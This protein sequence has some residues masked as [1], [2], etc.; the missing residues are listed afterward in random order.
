MFREFL[1]LDADTDSSNDCVRIDRLPLGETAGRDEAWLRDLLLAHTDLLPIREIDASYAPLLP[2]CKELRTEAGPIDAVFINPH[3]RL[4]LVECKLWRNPEA[5]RKVVAQI[6]DYARAISQWSYSDLQRNVSAATRRRGNVPFEVVREVF[7]DLQEHH[8]VDQVAA[9][10]RGG[11]FL[12]LIVGD[13]IRDDVSAMADMIT[14]NATLGFSFGIVEMALYSMPNRGLLLQPRVATRTHVIERTVVVLS[15]GAE[16]EV[17]AEQEDAP[18]PALQ[19]SAELLAA[20]GSDPAAGESASQAR[21]RAWWQ[22]VLEARLDDPDQEPGKLH[23]PNNIRLPLPWKKTWITAYRFSHNNERFLGVGTG[24][25]S[26]ADAELMRQL[27]PEMDNIL[28]ELPDG[29]EYRSSLIPGR[30]KVIACIKKTIDFV[31]EEAQKQWL[32][33]TVNSFVNALRPRIKHVLAAQEK[34]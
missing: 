23:W 1:L 31:D 7:P 33:E 27:E 19:E 5:R 14:R 24:G 18:I 12:L 16:Q 4:T 17:L 25:L 21:Y 8:F 13:G 26:G 9:S 6:L 3:G 29:T 28:A 34:A 2:L 22:P 15:R 11:R 10:L 30:G 20:E 32:S